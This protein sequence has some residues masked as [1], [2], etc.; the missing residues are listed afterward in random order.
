M[1]YFQEPAP[2]SGLCSYPPC[3]CDETSIPKGS[4]YLYITK[5]CVDFRQDALSL[6][7][8]SAKLEELQRR[9]DSMIILG[10]GVASP[11]LVCEEGAKKL[12]L[13]LDIAGADARHWW[14][15][16]QVPLRETP[17]KPREM[18]GSKVFMGHT[19]AIV[20]VALSQDGSRL[21]TAS[22]DS[23]RFW[24][25][26]TGKQLQC[27]AGL[28]NSQASAALSPD[29][30]LAVFEG[31]E[32]NF[33]TLQVWDTAQGRKLHVLKGH[34]WFVEAFAFSPDRCRLLTGGGDNKVRLWDLQSG[35]LVHCFGGFFGRNQGGPVTIV[36]FS[37]DGKTALS[38]GHGL[39][40]AS[41]W[42]VETGGRA[43]K[44]GA[45][46]IRAAAFLPNGRVTMFH[47]GIMS[48]WD[49]TTCRETSRKEG[50]VGGQSALAKMRGASDDSSTKS[51]PWVWEEL[52]VSADC[53]RLL[54]RLLGG[55]NLELFDLVSWSHVRTLGGH[56]DNVRCAAFSGDGRR[57]ASGSN[58]HTARTWDM[59]YIP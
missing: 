21:L 5:E 18:A 48:T 20:A 4:G 9:S 36:G 58:D 11:I 47:D 28:R 14:A 7:A 46:D 53:R 30:R 33:G 40:S 8:V 44:L 51:A 42:N 26:N 12:E 31:D 6:D 49:I 32:G 55:S 25:V 56:R 34:S 3:P 29:G 17:I 37:P 13:D 59:S 38:G 41:L 24:D 23:V 50:R 2:S 39:K 16:G 43:G 10:P 27:F 52:T 15:T 1:N 54:S 35:Q 22:E 19:S 45:P 57:A